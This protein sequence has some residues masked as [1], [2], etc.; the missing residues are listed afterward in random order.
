MR[1]LNDIYTEIPIG[2]HK[3]ILGDTIEVETIHGSVK[4]I[5]PKHTDSRKRFRLKGRGIKGGNHYVDVQI[6][7]PNDV[8]EGLEKAIKNWAKKYNYDP[9]EEKMKKSA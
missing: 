9:R 5:L 2:I 3:A 7:I 8:D 1:K 6:V 4:K